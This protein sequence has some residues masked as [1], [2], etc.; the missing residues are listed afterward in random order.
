M[1]ID[2][3]PI[4]ATLKSTAAGIW[5][6]KT[7][8][9]KETKNPRSLPPPSLHPLLSLR[10]NLWK[11]KPFAEPTTGDTAACWESEAH[12]QSTIDSSL[13]LHQKSIYWCIGT[14]FGTYRA[15]MRT[16]FKRFLW[17]FGITFLLL[18]P[19]ESVPGHTK[20]QHHQILFLHPCGRCWP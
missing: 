19:L 2:L 10:E 16:W 1:T 6:I 5:K 14:A 11:G 13:K 20:E 7:E 9:K 18:S 4:W 3:A 8:K 17:T 12:N 15:M